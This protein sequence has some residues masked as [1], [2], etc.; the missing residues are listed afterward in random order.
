MQKNVIFN[1]VIPGRSF[2]NVG[3]VN[4]IWE[5]KYN[6]QLSLHMD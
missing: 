4:G 1:G 5:W 2:G 6:W 3:Q